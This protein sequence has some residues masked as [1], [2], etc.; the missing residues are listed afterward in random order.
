[1]MSWLLLSKHRVRTDRVAIGRSE[2]EEEGAN[3]QVRE[4]MDSSPPTLL[5][6]SLLVVGRS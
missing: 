5:L 1:M 3:S 4:K 2:E 6:I